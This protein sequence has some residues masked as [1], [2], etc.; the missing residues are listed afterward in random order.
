MI[1]GWAGSGAGAALTTVDRSQNGNALVI[2]AISKVPLKSA[3]THSLL[4]KS[5]ANSTLAPTPVAAVVHA[6]RCRAAVLKRGPGRQTAVAKNQ[7]VDPMKA[8]DGR[9]KY[10]Q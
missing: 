7:A 3:K 6:P 5:R 2:L 4:P 10:M 8:E 9:R 1:I